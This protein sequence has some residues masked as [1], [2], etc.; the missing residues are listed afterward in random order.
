[1]TVRLVQFLSALCEAKIHK[2]RTRTSC[3]KPPPSP[4][5][6]LSSTI[7]VKQ[8][9]KRLLEQNNLELFHRLDLSEPCLPHR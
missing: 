2:P 6:Y 1:M 7:S 4:N 8:Q 5:C 3:S 9:E